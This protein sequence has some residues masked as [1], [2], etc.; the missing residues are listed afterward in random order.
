MSSTC[1][2]SKGAPFR[3]TGGYACGLDA[4]TRAL[5]TAAHPTLQSRA[6]AADLRV[7]PACRPPLPVQLFSVLVFSLCHLLFL[8]SAG[9]WME[10]KHTEEF[11]SLHLFKEKTTVSASCLH[12][13]PPLVVRTPIALEDPRGCRRSDIVRDTQA[14]LIFG[15]FY[16]FL[17]LHKI[18]AI[19]VR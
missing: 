15:T 11:P 17:M 14:I 16:C 19:P 3:S 13:C 4:S 12:C 10:I 18:R 7:L 5:P 9:L 2:R 1:M 8:S 6:R